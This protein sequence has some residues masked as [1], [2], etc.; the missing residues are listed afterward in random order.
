M[1]LKSYTLNSINEYFKFMIRSMKINIIKIIQ[2][3][4]MNDV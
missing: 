1:E 2:A 4:R 3:A